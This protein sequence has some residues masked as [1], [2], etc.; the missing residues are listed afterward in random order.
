M[1]T[2]MRPSQMELPLP[3]SFLG[4]LLPS[5]FVV[6]AVLVGAWL[7]SLQWPRSGL[8]LYACL[9]VLALIL[10][11]RSRWQA[12][13]SIPV[14]SPAQ[15]QVWSTLI[16]GRI[17]APASVAFVIC[18]GEF[19]RA[20]QNQFGGFAVPAGSGYWDWVR[21]SLSWVLDNTLANVGQIFGWTV[22]PIHP[23]SLAAQV[24]VFGYN[25]ILEFFLLALFI[26]FVR[27]ILQPTR[28]QW[29]Q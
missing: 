3:I 2:S 4:S 1:S 27:T 25:L 28:P 16:T 5:S 24:L 23:V 20:W 8:P 18:C 11:L 21:Y 15:R 7:L 13:E 19:F 10:V 22:T 26:R 9:I 17:V 29:G 6:T 14:E 12:V